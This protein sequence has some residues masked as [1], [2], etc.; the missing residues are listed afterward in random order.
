MN[1]R[2]QRELYSNV[3]QVNIATSSV[4]CMWVCFAANVSSAR[5]LLSAVRVA[6]DSSVFCSYVGFTALWP[7]S[8]SLSGTRQLLSAVRV[9]KRDLLMSNKS[10]GLHQTGHV[11]TLLFVGLSQQLQV[12]NQIPFFLPHAAT[13]TYTELNGRH[14]TCVRDVIGSVSYIRILA[15]QALGPASLV[16]RPLP[17]FQRTR[18]FLVYIEKLGVA[19]GRG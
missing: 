11:A 15:L 1:A 6:N 18:G 10:Q 4:F 17:A 2:L 3:I 12:H 13:C 8:V 5:Q 19:W 14:Y 7:F 16:P 9:A